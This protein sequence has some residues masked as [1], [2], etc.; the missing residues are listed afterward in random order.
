M[1]TRVVAE[2]VGWFLG[3][4]ALTVPGASAADLVCRDQS[5]AK[6]TSAVLTVSARRPGALWY[7]Q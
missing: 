5:A 1:W 7:C 3:P 2:R 4:A 6:V